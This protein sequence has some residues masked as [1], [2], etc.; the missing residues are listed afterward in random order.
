MI[1]S[2]KNVKVFWADAPK[3]GFQKIVDVNLPYNANGCLHIQATVKLAFIPLGTLR[4]C[5]CLR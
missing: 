4:L 1:L 2:V 5:F 3:E